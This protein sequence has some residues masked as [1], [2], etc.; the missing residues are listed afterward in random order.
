MITCCGSVQAWVAESCECSR[1][2]EALAMPVT[3]AAVIPKF[4][5]I[6]DLTPLQRDAI[7]RLTGIAKQFKAGEPVAREGERPTSVTLIVSGMLCR[8]KILKDGRRQI[9]AFHTPGDIPDMQ[10]IHIRKMDHT[11]AAI[12]PS[13]LVVIPHATV[14][15]FLD[16]HPDIAALCWRD[17]LIDAAIL[18]EWMVGMGRRTAYARTAHL[19]CEI[20]L[21]LHAVG[22]AG[23]DACDL[24]LTQTDLA[25]ALGL[26]SVHVN[27][28]LQELRAA[29]LVDLRRGKLRITDWPGLME[30]GEFDPGYLQLR[31]APMTLAAASSI[32]LN[33]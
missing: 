8:F 27:R 22:I 17:T 29:G 30:A 25:D 4:E 15:A 14:H 26:S 11:L 10:S 13:T 3:A 2:S 9:I 5:S 19:F 32:Q 7:A 18:R 21:K 16:R 20:I 1:L 12:A 23:A 6:A 31:A 33:P 24:P 28:T